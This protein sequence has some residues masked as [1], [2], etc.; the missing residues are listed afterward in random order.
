[1]E[2]RFIKT[3]YLRKDRTISGKEKVVLVAK[4][5][6]GNKKLKE[7]TDP[8]M[9]FYV[10]KKE[11]WLDDVTL[12]LPKEHVNKVFCKH[13][14]VIKKVVEEAG[15]T[16][17]KAELKRILNSR[18]YQEMRKLNSFHLLPNAHGSDINIEDYVISQFRNEFP[19]HDIPIDIL[20]FDIEVDGSDINGFPDPERAEAPINIIT[21]LD[22]SKK[23]C[24]TFALKYDNEEYKTAM[25]DEG[26]KKI[27]NDLKE[28]YNDEHGLDLEFE[29]YEFD[30]EME[31]IRAFLYYVNEISRPDVASAWNLGFDFTTIFERIRRNGES[32]EVYFS[33]NDLPD[34][35]AYYK[36]DKKAKDAA[37]R[38]DQFVTNSYT[39]WI[40]H[41]SLYANIQKPNGAL[42]SLRLNDIGLK[43][44]GVAKD[45]YEGS[46]SDLHL[47]DYYTFIMYNIK[48][49]VLEGMIEAAT[50]M[51]DLLFSLVD[52][53]ATRPSKALK[54]SISLRNYIS[55]FLEQQGQVLSNNHS[56]LYKGTEESE[57]KFKGGFVANMLQINKNGISLFGD[58]KSN[59][60]FKNVC[61]FDL[62]SLYPSLITALA[63]N[64][65]GLVGKIQLTP[66]A[67]ER[68]DLPKYAESDSYEKDI[69]LVDKFNSRN[70]LLV[71]NQFYDLE[72]PIDAADS[73][74]AE[75]EDV[76]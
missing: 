75:M 52:I 64:E 16:T 6:E 13:K 49:T 34:K 29:I 35:Y 11:N 4:D 50:N 47:R 53:T 73:I 51:F 46:I 72:L 43:E 67:E 25:S 61:D 44:A 36:L 24:L 65:Q 23:K 42:E 30:T 3:T 19:N 31:V 56:A 32:P 27:F 70:S 8:T 9:H 68:I 17:D 45:V 39:N 69:D 15:T 48:D 57:K 41:L 63:L 54:K 60:I 2:N 40:D 71:T 5:K 14:D 28:L 26:K 10:T 59:R 66:E 37:E 7:I 74:I 38:G 55:L 12:N 1:M 22:W 58:I 21:A 20:F 62:E 18:D 33:A 76:S